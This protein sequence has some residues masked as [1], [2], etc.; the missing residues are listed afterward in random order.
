MCDLIV[1]LVMKSICVILVFD[2]FWLISVSIF[3]LCV[4]R[5]ISWVLCVVVIGVVLVV[6][7]MCCIGGVVEVVMMLL[8]E[9][10]FEGWIVFVVFVD[11]FIFLGDVVEVVLVSE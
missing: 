10:G 6:D 9:G 8:V 1:F 11:L 2:F 4:V 3:C 5:F 7:E